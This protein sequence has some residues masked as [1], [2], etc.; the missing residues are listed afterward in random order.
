M[1]GELFRTM[2]SLLGVDLNTFERRRSASPDMPYHTVT[3]EVKYK[4]Q[5]DENGKKIKVPFVVPNFQSFKTKDLAISIVKSHTLP[6]P[7]GKYSGGKVYKE[8][9]LEPI[10]S[11]LTLDHFDQE[12]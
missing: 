2:A 3:Y 4:K 10:F 8:G 9:E 1:E 6:E 11:S 7:Y 5:Y 12:E